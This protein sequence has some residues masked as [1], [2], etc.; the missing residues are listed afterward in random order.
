MLRGGSFRCSMT[1]EGGRDIE[2]KESST[3]RVLLAVVAVELREVI[4]AL[5]ERECVGAV[6]R[7]A[8]SAVVPCA[9]QAVTCT[10]RE[11]TGIESRGKGTT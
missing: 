10:E 9:L 8:D 1:A 4:V 2:R 5:R 7:L 6:P 11:A 3:S